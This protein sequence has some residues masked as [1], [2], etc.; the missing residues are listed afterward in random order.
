MA[1][2]KQ[3][4]IGGISGERENLGRREVGKYQQ[5]E[6]EVRHTVQRGRN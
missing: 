2:A 1:I 4:G 6:G 3:E 5:D